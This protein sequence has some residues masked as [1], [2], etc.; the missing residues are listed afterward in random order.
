MV[1]SKEESMTKSK[2]T[3]EANTT[4]TKLGEISTTPTKLDEISDLELDKVTGGM[5]KS[6]GTSSSAGTPFLRFDLKT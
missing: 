3:S 6:A 1:H 5:R 2:K 4:P